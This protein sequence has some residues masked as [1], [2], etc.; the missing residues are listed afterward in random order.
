MQVVPGLL[1]LA[2]LAQRRLLQ[3]AWVLGRAVRE[4]PVVQTP[5]MG[6]REQR[7]ATW[8]GTKAGPVVMPLREQVPFPE[9]RLF[10]PRPVVE[11][12][13]FPPDHSR[14]LSMPPTVDRLETQFGTL[15]MAVEAVPEVPPTV[16]AEAEEVAVAMFTSRPASSWSLEPGRPSPPTEETAEPLA[17]R[18]GVVAVAEVE[19]PLS[20]LLRR[21]I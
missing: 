14:T 17:E 21:Q 1:E 9:L 7:R 4:A 2:A 11:P 8:S 20:S 19:A 18:K 5:L 16:A 15:E 3:A 6:R 13:P 10:S 12:E